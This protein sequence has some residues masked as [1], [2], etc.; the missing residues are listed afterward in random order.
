MPEIISPAQAMEQT[1]NTDLGVATVVFIN[2]NDTLFPLLDQVL[3]KLYYG[4]PQVIDNP[5]GG[6]SI[7]TLT[8]RY[9]YNVLPDKEQ[10]SYIN[11]LIN[12][13]SLPH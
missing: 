12:P 13:E 2:Y 7:Q 9:N 5:E 1:V 6:P 4:T 8:I 3:T 11:S 10:I